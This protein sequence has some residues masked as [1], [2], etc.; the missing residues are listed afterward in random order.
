MEM[1][2]RFYISE[3]NIAGAG[4]GLFAK[5][6]LAKGEGLQVLGVLIPANSVSDK[7]T[8]YA[9]SYKFRVG[10]D[11]LIP[12]G[13]GAMVN[14]SMDPNL[15]KLIEGERIAL[16]VLRPISE[17]EE[18]LFCYSEYA[19]TRFGLGTGKQTV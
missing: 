13:Y 1:D 17:G 4:K 16:R 14:H 19:Q 8:H 11:L 10:N 6:P 3:S 15:E 18:L 12:M 5:V 7:C 9:D 2:E